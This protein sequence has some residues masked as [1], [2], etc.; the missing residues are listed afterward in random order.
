M[1]SVWT[2]LHI[3]CTWIW[4]HPTLVS[5]IN[6]HRSSINLLAELIAN[7]GKIDGIAMTDKIS[8]YW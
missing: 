8:K 1:L 2:T 6:L 4:N 5:R 3:L 7:D